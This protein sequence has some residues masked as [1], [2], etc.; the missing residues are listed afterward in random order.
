M[1]VIISGASSGIGYALT[2]YYVRAGATVVALARRTAPLLSLNT[3]RPQLLYPFA[4]DVTDRNGIAEIVASV[5]RSLG[6]IDIAI[7]CAGIAEEQNS[8]DFDL[9]ALDRAL[10]TNVLG[11]FNLLA[12]AAAVMRQRAR[13]QLVAISSLAAER[14]LPRIAAYCI[15][16]AALNAG[17]E[18][19]DL[20]VGSAGVYVTTVCPSF[21]ATKMTAGRIA[22]R[23]CMCLERAVSRIVR[24]I[25][26]R[27]RIYRF[28]FC[29]YLLLC[30][31]RI[32][33]IKLRRSALEAAANV[34][35]PTNKHQRQHL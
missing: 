20:L 24:A 33:P 9:T 12:P 16:K 8:P 35:A 34:L 18:S 31:I 23:R 5:E 13:G 6:P 1:I 11:T 28:P 17:M 30:L 27:K 29:S 4:A 10:N 25:E 2:E 21:I 19:L 26:R 22:P 15:S 3:A 7:A 32:I 14:S